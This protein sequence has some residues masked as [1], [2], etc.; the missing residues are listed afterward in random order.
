MKLLMIIIDSAHKV[1][2]EVLLNRHEILGYTEIP[3]VLGTGKTG[4][5]MGSR[6]F[7]KTSSLIFTVIPEEVLEPLMEDVRRYCEACMKNMKMIVW[8]VEQIV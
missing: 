6:A 7:P 2:L 3:Q 8:K 4:P 1:E 5:R